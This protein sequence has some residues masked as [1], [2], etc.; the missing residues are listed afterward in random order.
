MVEFN[1]AWQDMTRAEPEL[2]MRDRTVHFQHHKPEAFGIPYHF[3]PSIEVN[4]LQGCDMT[5]SFSG[6]KVIVPDGSCCVFWAAHP[7]KALEVSNDGWITNA[8]ISLS[9]FMSWP[10]PQEFTS[11]LLGG[12]VM[13][14]DVHEDADQALVTRWSKETS[15]TSLSWQRVHLVELQARLTRMAAT[16]W[17]AIHHH[18]EF[19]SNSSV[20]TGM[21]QFEKMLRFVAEN[22]SRPI[23]IDEVASE[24]GVTTNQALILFRKLLG[25]TIKGHITDLRIYHAKMLLT[26]SDE[27]IINVSQDCGYSSLSAF[28]DAFKQQTGMSPAVFRETVKD[29]FASE[30]SLLN[31]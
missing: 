2:G 23:G 14:A 15:E 28:Y 27:K 24:G 16:G 30:P 7:H 1:P 21:I 6:Q 3:H 19:A 20:A 17:R 13:L 5:Y 10:F 18:S 4:F 12:C 26:E 25:R 22:F 9:T 8:Y 29:E 11:A 31:I